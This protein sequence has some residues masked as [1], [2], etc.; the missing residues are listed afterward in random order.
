MSS[1]ESVESRIDKKN[2]DPHQRAIVPAM[3]NL[4][5]ALARSSKEIKSLLHGASG[6][7]EMPYFLR[8]VT[9]AV[10]NDPT[11]KLMQCCRTKEG[12]VSVVKAAVDAAKYGLRPNTI[13]Q[14]A[15]L[16]PRKGLVTLQLGKNGLVK[17]AKRAGN[18]SMIGG[19]AVYEGEL[20][21][22]DPVENAV[23][24]TPDMGAVC[25][26]NGNNV[27][28][29]YAWVVF[30]DGNKQFEVLRKGDIERARKAG[31][32]TSPSWKNHYDKMAER[33]AIARLCR[34]KLPLDEKMVELFGRGA[35]RSEEEKALR[36][37]TPV[38]AVVEPQ[39]EHEF[40]P[41]GL[42]HDIHPDTGEVLDDS[43]GGGGDSLPPEEP[44]PPTEEYPPPAKEEG[45]TANDV[46]DVGKTLGMNLK[47][48][49]E[50]LG[51]K[52]LKGMTPEQ[53]EAACKSL[54]SLG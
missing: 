8:L 33:S 40:G 23:K 10:E 19:Q 31:Y 41:D 54:R 51:V 43:V 27:V 26:P 28:A 49:K 25:A 53:C 35:P 45:L 11:Q 36:N 42:I 24:H 21:E 2:V 47:Q 48:I 9:S 50:H 32:D 30:A 4:E 5:S 38:E 18:V 13:A 44:P 15:F 46:V 29:A 12:V 14:E 52:T 1:Q 20:F 17:M 16:I 6:D 37:V 7:M 22:W 39:P 3:K 34:S